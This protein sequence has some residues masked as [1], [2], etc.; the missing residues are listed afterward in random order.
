MNVSGLLRQTWAATKIVLVFTVI[1]GVLYPA[2]VWL[3]SRAP[4]LEHRAEGSIVTANG[5]AVGSSLIGLNP[6][7][8]NATKTITVGGH[9]YADDRYFHT[10]PSALA[11][12]FSLTD[13]TKLGLG[14]NDGSSSGASNLS[15]DSSI[16][17][18]QIAARRTVIAK[19]DGVGPGQ[20]P[21]DAVTASASGVDPGIS[22][23]YADEQAARV[24][25][26][27][28]LPLATV[29]RIIAD[30]T[31]GPGMGVLGSASVNVQAL[32]LAVRQAVAAQGG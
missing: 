14:A 18:A 30:D 26:V 19:R 3:V 13:K 10:R 7:D 23:A 29:R 31:T 2:A 6:I 21:P 15:Q 22:V 25:A 9:A 20:V 4:G 12:D 27:N 32:N 16:L 28:R 5:T 8:P 11:S 24:A 17:A 1:T